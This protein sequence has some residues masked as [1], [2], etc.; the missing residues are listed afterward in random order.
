MPWWISRVE[1][2]RDA[3]SHA[4]R[5]NSIELL[6][7]NRTVDL[8]PGLN[9][10]RGDI[11]TGKTT[12]VRLLR[13]FLGNIPKHMPPEMEQVRALTG[14]VLLG[15]R[16]WKLYRPMVT[17][18][19]APVE[20]AE[21]D[22]SEE[23]EGIALRLPA[24]GSAGYGEF[25]L[26][27]LGLPVVSVP[28]ARKEPTLDQTPVTIN[29]WLH[30][31]IVTGDELDVQVFGHRETFRDHKR[32]WVFEIAYG[33]YDEELARLSAQIR[34]VDLSIR[35][36][37]AEHEVVAAFLAEAEFGSK[38]ELEGTL[39]AEQETLSAL[40]QSQHD[41]RSAF[42]HEPAEE[43]AALRA[44]VLDL[45][46][47][48]DADKAELRQHEAQLRDL[49]DLERQLVS[50]SKRLTRSIVADEWMV[51]F[52]FIVCPRCG[53]DLDRHRVET[54]ICYLCEQP[55]P[56][57]AP[58]RETLLREQDRVTFQI[59]ETKQ[60]IEERRYSL[61]RLRNASNE[62]AERL[63]KLSVQL[64]Q[65]TEQFVSSH[66]SELKALA[67]Q[68][69]T[70][71]ANVAWLLR[72]LK[73]FAHQSNQQERLDILRDRKAELEADL[74]AHDVAVSEAEENIAAL[75]ARMLDYLQRLNAPTL[76]D[77]LTVRINRTSYLPE[78]SGRTF[79][80][81]SSQ[82]LKTI[83]NVA[84]TLAHHTVAIDRGLALPGF[85]VLDGVS[86][87]SGKDGLDGERVLDMYRL[88]A[89]ISDSYS[90]QLQI[91]VVDNELP[92]EIVA[93]L[94]D[95]IVLTLSQNDRLIVGPAELTAT[96][97]Q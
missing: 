2:V 56:D 13:G 44:G 11:T 66:A 50:L 79:D 18:K 70:V 21:A 91:L 72:S 17:T 90:D 85:V 22:S 75:E 37:E 77:L 30:Y 89:E 3:S 6:G 29:D 87:N 53:H 40:Q 86:A 49:L 88:F 67:A 28:R 62:G 12:L 59:A 95:R 26:Q 8:K 60:L 9:L 51:D 5:I 65:A 84:H 45:R 38:E 97:D 61:E 82:G 63:I 55:E 46:K 80:E 41:T 33:L 16:L 39:E 93:D 4:L 58:N 81:L 35:A 42:E 47:E 7:G 20:V 32:R 74:E 83:V 25:V 92:P 31:C 14:E 36:A 76:G 15:D 19:D 68:V 34:Q 69:A 78:V 54:S 57:I 43:I 94:N 64:D 1:H 48:I 71:E 52:D 10:I 96:T 27:Q 24:A 73:L 23:V